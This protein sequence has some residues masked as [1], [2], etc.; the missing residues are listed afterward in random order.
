MFKLIRSFAVVAAILGFFDAHAAITL[1]KDINQ[2]T[3]PGSAGTQNFVTANG[4]TFFVAIDAP[5]GQELWCTDGTSAGTHIVRDIFPGTGSPGLERIT[6]VNDTVYFFA[7]DG[8]NGLELWRSDGTTSGTHIV[9]DIKKGAASSIPEFPSVGAIANIGG[10][11]YFAADDGSGLGLWRSDGTASGTY[12]ASN[13]KLF[14]G[15]LTVVGQRLFFLGGAAGGGGALWT[16]DGTAAGTKQV[17]SFFSGVS[18]SSV[19]WLTPT[20]SG[21]FFEATDGSGKVTLAFASS[22]GGS[23]RSIADLTQTKISSI[24]VVAMAP[25][26]GDVVLDLDG[27][28]LYHADANGATL[29]APQVHTLNGFQAVG[30]HQLFSVG[31]GNGPF[32]LWTTDGT[33]S[34]THQLRVDVGLASNAPVGSAGQFVIGEDGFDYFGGSASLSST[35]GIWRTDGTDAGTTP[36]VAAPGGAPLIPISLVRFQQKIWFSYPCDTNTACLWSSDG[37][38]AGTKAVFDPTPLPTVEGLAVAGS[39]LFFTADVAQQLFISDGTAAGSHSLATFSTDGLGNDSSPSGFTGLN[40]KVLFS[41]NDGIHGFELWASDASTHETHMLFDLNPGAGQGAGS[42]PIAIGAL[43][44]FAGNDGVHGYQLWVTDGTAVGTTLLANATPELDPSNVAVLNGVAYFPADDGVHGFQPWRS[45]GTVAGT[46]M[47]ADTGQGTFASNFRVFNGRLMFYSGPLFQWWIT[48]GTAPGTHAVTQAGNSS[49]QE[50]IL[51]GLFYFSGIAN[52]ANTGDLWV[53]DGTTAGT[54]TAMTLTSGFIGGVYGLNSRM[55]LSTM[56]NPGANTQ[57]A[58]LGTDGTLGGTIQVA[59]DSFFAAVVAGNQLIYSTPNADGTTEIR[60]TDGTIAGTRDVMKVDAA[61]P[62]LGLYKGAAIFTALKTVEPGTPA[63]ASIWRTDGTSQGTRVV[64]SCPAASFFQAIGNAL[65][66][67]GN[68]AAIGAEPYV[69]DELSPNAAPDEASTAAET[70]VTVDVLANDGSLSSTLVPSSVA[71]S[72]AP[73][74]GS[75]SIDPST[76]KITYTPAK[77]FSGTDTFTYVVMDTLGLESAPTNVD[78]VVGAE[79]GPPPGSAPSA[80]PTNAGPSP[81]PSKGGG[82]ALS[83]AELAALFGL[84]VVLRFARGVP[85]IQWTRLR[86][87]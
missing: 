36:Y 73:A 74:N 5:H 11:L 47:I 6:V 2:S 31:S 59:S 26:G 25:L 22:D 81:S 51:N 39:A 53:T 38:T 21:I 37:T 8:V 57:V 33:T 43:A 32:E 79:A 56:V 85:R 63:L 4:L 86:S 64:A 52:G 16:S 49:G 1:L 77:G 35:A 40:G 60:A 68:T 44:I 19:G 72:A 76:G 18:Q 66:F 28:G 71:I 80:P 14:D 34:G 9:A 41:A 12:E 45:D 69:V 54:H 29:I 27:V 24:G 84:A 13:V 62:S 65:Y 78:V 20:S 10:I 30:G 3:G 42:P 58:L 7:N 83:L 50:A 55:L 15:T 61:G 23:S 48:D 70:S 17:S 46:Y 87:V 75:A 82:G 67:Q